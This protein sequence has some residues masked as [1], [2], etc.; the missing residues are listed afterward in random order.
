MDNVLDVFIDLVCEYFIEYFC[1]N[2]HKENWS[3]M[4]FLCG[5]FVWFMYHGDHYIA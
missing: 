5:V 3:E 4:L 1:I 2:V